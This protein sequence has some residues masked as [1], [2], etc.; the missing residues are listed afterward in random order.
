MFFEWLGVKAR[1]IGRVGFHFATALAV[2]IAF[3]SGTALQSVHAQQSKL[4]AAFEKDIKDSGLTAKRVPGKDVTAF[5]VP[6]KRPTLGSFDVVIMLTDDM[7]VFNVRVAKKSEIK[8]TPELIQGLLVDNFSKDYVKIGFTP[9]G[10]LIVRY[11]IRLTGIDGD[12]VKF[13]VKKTA[14]SADELAKSAAA[15]IKR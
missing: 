9:A 8:V 13:L 5:M 2:L 7:V 11:D 4:I 14:D 6:V 10:D 3:C 12:E 15:F 1:S